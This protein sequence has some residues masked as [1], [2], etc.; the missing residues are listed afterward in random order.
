MMG[1]ILFCL[2][3]YQMEEERETDPVGAASPCRRFRRMASKC[4]RERETTTWW[5][6]TTSDGGGFNGCGRLVR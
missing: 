4:K 6:V 5:S 2:L 3:N 1:Y